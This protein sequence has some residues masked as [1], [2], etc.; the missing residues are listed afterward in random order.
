M[1]Q[2]EILPEKYMR[3]R[4]SRGSC[5][6]RR[7]ELP[8]ERFSPLIHSG[9]YDSPLEYEKVHIHRQGVSRVHMLGVC[10][11]GGYAGLKVF[12]G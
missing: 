5:L 2:L 11:Q 6:P 10:T 7:H 4:I 1:I 8:R 9:S 3:L 12:I